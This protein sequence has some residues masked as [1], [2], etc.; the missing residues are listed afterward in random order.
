MSMVFTKSIS[1]NKIAISITIIR[2][3]M[4]FAFFWAG[5]G[6]ATNPQGFAMVLQNMV[7]YEPEFAVT[8]AFLI[9]VFELISGAFI[10]LGFLT[11]PAAIFQVVIAIGAMVMFGFDFSAGPAIWKDPTILAVAIGLAIY[12]SGKFGIDNI[13]SNKIKSK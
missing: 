6:K 2:I 3:G 5:F 9:G 7:G 1:E 11:R 10:L 13:I 4:A 12:G 8:M